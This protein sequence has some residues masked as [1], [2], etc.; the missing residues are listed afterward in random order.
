M[1]HYMDLRIICI[2]KLKDIEN[3]IYS[4]LKIPYYNRTASVTFTLL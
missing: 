4:F 3:L 2:H 1:L